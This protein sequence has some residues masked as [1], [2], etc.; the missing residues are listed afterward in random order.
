MHFEEWVALSDSARVEIQK[1]WNPYAEG[2]WTDLLA[3]AAARFRGEFGH[4]PH[5]VDVAHGVYHGG[6][7]IIGVVTDLP[8]AQRLDLPSSYLGFRLMQ[9]WKGTQSDTP[10][11]A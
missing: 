4:L 8:L 3:Q 2:Y 11:D 10:A 9:F 7:L 5:L 6:T 1:D